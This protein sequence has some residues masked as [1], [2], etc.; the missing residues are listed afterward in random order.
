M[1]LYYCMCMLI[2]VCASAQPAVARHVG[3]LK[4]SALD[5]EDTFSRILG[6]MCPH[7]TINVSSARPD[8]ARHVDFLKHLP[9]GFDSMADRPWTSWCSSQAL[10]KH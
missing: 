3:I 2:P 1:S 8:V 9:Q 7:T 4:H 10:V 6:D 5:Y